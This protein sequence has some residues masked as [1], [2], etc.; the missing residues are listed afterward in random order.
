MRRA[1]VW[2]LGGRS[3]ESCS[4]PKKHPRWHM[5]GEVVLL[6]LVTSSASVSMTR[7]KGQG[8]PVFVYERVCEDKRERER[9]KTASQCVFVCVCKHVCSWAIMAAL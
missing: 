5:R 6:V 3:V 9:G 2:V 7:D 4:L 1:W 8:A